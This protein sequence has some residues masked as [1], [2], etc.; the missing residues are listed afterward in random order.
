MKKISVLFVL[1]CCSRI[2]F[3]E[4][5]TAIPLFLDVQVDQLN[6]DRPEEAESPS[7]SRS[8]NQ[9]QALL[10]AIQTLQKIPVK[11]IKVEAKLVNELLANPTKASHISEIMNGI[12]RVVIWMNDA[13]INPFSDNFEELVIKGSVQV[14]QNP[15]Q[16]AALIKEVRECIVTISSKVDLIF[17]ASHSWKKK[18][19][20]VTHGVNVDEIIKSVT[21]KVTKDEKLRLFNKFLKDALVVKSGFAKKIYYMLDQEALPNCEVQV[22]DKVFANKCLFLAEFLRLICSEEVVNPVAQEAKS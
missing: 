8:Q 1:A 11:K 5:E 6:C 16:N 22:Q 15:S 10:L 20:P 17:E 19:A 14:L 21:A 13:G 18:A 2:H 4:Q 12:K 7:E 3:A 9:E